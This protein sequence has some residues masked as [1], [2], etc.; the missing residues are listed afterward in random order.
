MTARLSLALPVCL[1][2][3]P[4]G[5][6][7]NDFKTALTGGKPVVD[8]RVRAETVDQ[9]NALEDGEALTTRLRLGYQTGDYRGLSA[10][11]RICDS[12]IASAR[13]LPWRFFVPRYRLQPRLRRL[14]STAPP[15]PLTPAMVLVL[16]ARQ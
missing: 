1:A 2:L 14:S 11:L 3:A 15:T 8:L 5:A 7:A 10:V 13:F 4:F 9:D 16:C 6:S 12:D